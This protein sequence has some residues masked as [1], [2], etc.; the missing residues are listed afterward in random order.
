MPS[1]LRRGR[2]SRRQVG[3]AQAQQAL[4]TLL[5][6]A[7]R[8]RG[9]LAAVIEPHGIT[10][11][12]YNVLRILRGAQAD[13]LPTLSIAERL[14]ERAPGITRMLDRL[15]RQDLVVRERRMDDRRCVHCR[16]TTRGLALLRRLDEPVSRANQDV[17]AEFSADDV[18]H[19]A[20]MLER[21]ART[22]PTDDIAGAAH[23]D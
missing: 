15:E 22:D 6:A 12:Q 18:T 19:L 14:I 13:G 5:R 20:K 11:P 7:D 8:A 10:G 16:L 4:V 23:E 9:R 21:V 3:G 2:A 17:F 1:K